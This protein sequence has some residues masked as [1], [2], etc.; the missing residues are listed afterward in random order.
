MMNTEIGYIYVEISVRDIEKTSCLPHYGTIHERDASASIAEN[1]GIFDLA[2]VHRSKVASNI[3]L[4]SIIWIEFESTMERSV[5][6]IREPPNASQ[7]KPFG[8]INIWEHRLPPR[9]MSHDLDTS[10]G[11]GEVWTTNALRGA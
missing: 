6:F 5:W 10:Y 3:E 1:N 8:K 9:I 4:Q 2:L 11:Y 7:L